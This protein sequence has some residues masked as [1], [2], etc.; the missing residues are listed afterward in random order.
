MRESIQSA[1]ASG[2]AIL[3]RFSHDGS[4]ATVIEYAMIASGIAVAIIVVVRGLGVAVNDQYVGFAGL[5]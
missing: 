4:G 5:F 3:R 2:N 1:V